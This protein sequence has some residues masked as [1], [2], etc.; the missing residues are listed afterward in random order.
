MG[1]DKDKSERLK[2]YSLTESTENTEIFQLKT[3]TKR[4]SL[5]EFTEDTEKYMNV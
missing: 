1:K 3:K 4:I 2:E 5:T